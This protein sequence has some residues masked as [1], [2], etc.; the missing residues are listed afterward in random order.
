MTEPERGDENADPSWVGYGLGNVAGAVA[1]AVSGMMWLAA[2]FSV[3]AIICAI[4]QFRST[5]R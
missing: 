5:R 2:V 1:T 4:Q 3:L